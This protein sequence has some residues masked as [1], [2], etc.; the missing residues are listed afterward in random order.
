MKRLALLIVLTLGSCGVLAT[1]HPEADTTPPPTTCQED[2][3]CWDCATMGNRIC[4][5]P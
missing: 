4:G 2:M 1:Y 5:R 3:P